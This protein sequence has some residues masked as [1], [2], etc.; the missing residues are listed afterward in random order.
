[1]ILVRRLV[2][3]GTSVGITL[4]RALLR[5]RGYKRGD[6]FLLE[7]DNGALVLRHVTEADIGKAMRAAA[8][9]RAAREQRT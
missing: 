3:I 8:R 7:I 9:D 4:P 6:S 1:M 5:E 2:S